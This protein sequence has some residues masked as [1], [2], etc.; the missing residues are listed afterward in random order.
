MNFALYANQPAEVDL[1]GASSNA[2]SYSSTATGSAYAVFYCP[3]A[4]TCSNVL[5][6]LIYSALPTFPWSLSVPI[7]WD[8]SAWT[9]WSAEGVDDGGAHRVSLAIYNDD[10]SATIYTVRVYDSTGALVGT[11]T[12]PSIPG[13]PLLSDGS[14]GE[15][16]T[17]GALLSDVIKTRLP[18]GVFKVLVDGGTKYSGVEV[19]Q[20]NGQSAT[21]LQVAY[22]T[23]P[24][25]SSIATAAL[26]SEV[27]TARVAAR[28][29]QVFGTVPK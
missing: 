8:T 15:G 17:Y 10:F 22:D 7:T 29:K 28:P 11:G 12:T 6:Q 20:V 18:S 21:T 1:L 19:L 27:R 9:Q 5:P 14:Y 2:P 16:G 23:A 3:D 13:L 24:G 25:S 4:G 26:R